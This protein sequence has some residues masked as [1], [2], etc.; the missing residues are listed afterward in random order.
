M[1]APAAPRG[2]TAQTVNELIARRDEPEWMRQRRLDAWN[3]YESI[4]MPTRQD[5]E[6]RRTD[7]RGLRLN[8]V[9]PYS[10]EHAPPRSLLPATEAAENFAGVL[11]FWNGEPVD[12]RLSEDLKR[13]GVIFTD[14]RTAVREYP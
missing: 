2:F 11:S 5:E 14:M 13:R 6:W 4:P 3:I 9:A 7:L 12:Y 1:T 10:D 8:E